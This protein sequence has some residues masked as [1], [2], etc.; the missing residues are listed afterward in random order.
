LSRPLE[1]ALAALAEAGLNLHGVLD[2]TD[3]DALVPPAWRSAATLDGARSVLVL[4]SGGRAI[5]E[6][7]RASA[8]ADLPNDPLDA[9]TRRVVEAAALRI[10]HAGAGARPLF[11]Y[12]RHGGGFADFVALGRACGLGVESRLRILLHPRFGPWLAIRA[13]L[14]TDRVIEPTPPF[15]DFAPCE[16]CP[17]PCAGA[18]RGSALAQGSLATSLCLETRRRDP[19]CELRCDARRACVVGPEHA[20]ARDA[21]AHHMRAALAW[22]RAL[23]AAP[24]TP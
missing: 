9:F 1:A 22:V 3:Y 17:A 8:E 14:L 23:D 12:E 21:E 19:A 11:Y 6:R 24:V 20:Y 7:F 16:G 10:A 13:V 15:R 4:A 18:C 2:P 5:F